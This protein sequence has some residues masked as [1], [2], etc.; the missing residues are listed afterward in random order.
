LAVAAAVNV[1]VLQRILGH[2]AAKM[3]LNT[4]AGLFD[5]DLDAVAAICTAERPRR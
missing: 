3:T 4:N 1:L 5:D 2:R